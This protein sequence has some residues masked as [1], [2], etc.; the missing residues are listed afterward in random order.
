MKSEGP[1][2]AAL[3]DPS[4]IPEQKQ[5]TTTKLPEEFPLVTPRSSIDDT[6]HEEMP[7]MLQPKEES[8][9]DFIPSDGILTQNQSYGVLDGTG[10]AT[11]TK[12]A[13]EIYEIK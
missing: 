7:K 3:P 13:D 5:K 11:H 4:T 1:I 2:K 10:S 8:T 6:S 12:P 9:Y